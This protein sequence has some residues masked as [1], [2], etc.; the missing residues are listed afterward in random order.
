EL[1]C[2]QMSAFANRS[3]AR[4]DGLG[5]L[6]GLRAYSLSDGA[7]AVRFLKPWAR[8]SLDPRRWDSLQHL[9]RVYRWSF[10]RDVQEFVKMLRLDYPFEIQASVGCTVLPGNTSQSFFQAAFQGEEILSFQG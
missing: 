4:T 6:G 7:D 8:G 5:L 1:R 2:L 10:T 3:W 9:F